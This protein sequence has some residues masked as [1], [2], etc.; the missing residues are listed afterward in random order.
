M[1][2]LT[3]WMK[4]EDIVLRKIS[5]SQK[6]ITTVQFHLYEVPR[7]IKFIKTENSSC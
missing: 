1:Q 4:L 5:Q 2:Y 6:K 7:V 3:S